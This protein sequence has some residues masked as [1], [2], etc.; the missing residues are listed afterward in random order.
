MS[1]RR[2]RPLAT[3]VAGSAL[4]G[5]VT[6]TSLA[7]MNSPSQPT[8]DPLP[9]VR[10]IYG[11][12]DSG[13]PYL[14]LQRL[15]ANTV[16]VLPDRHLLNLVLAR[17]MKAV[18]W[19]GEYHRATCRFE[20]TDAEIEVLVDRVAHHPAIAAYQIAD[21]P[22]ATNCPNSPADIKARAELVSSI[23]SSKPTYVTVDSWNGREAFP[24]DDFVG[25]TDI[26]GLVV[27][28]CEAEGCNLSAI[29]SAIGSAEAAGV[30]RYWAVIQGFGDEYYSMPD[31]DTFEAQLDRWMNSDAEGI[32]I[33]AWN[34]GVDDVSRSPEIQDAIRQAWVPGV[35]SP[36]PSPPPSTT[37]P[38]P[39]STTPPSEPPPS[40]PSTT[41]PPTSSP[42]QPTSIPTGPTSAST[43]GSRDG[44]SPSSNPS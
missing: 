37:P 13:H 15:G 43:D 12:S 18:V 40:P 23:D 7:V 29:D 16:H 34:F 41:P 38:A 10:A 4:V 30:E 1:R 2:I 36:T 27:Y 6:A 28:P 26:M 17:G 5:A 11:E 20:F 44:T 35:P 31:V 24:Y 14:P 3:L 9:S 39:P 8:P 19:L 42:S 32:A 22:R 21:E 33:F 25:T